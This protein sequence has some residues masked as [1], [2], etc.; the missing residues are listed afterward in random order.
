M[1]RYKDKTI[2]ITGASSGIGKAFA[3]RLDELGAN[4]ILTARSEDKLIELASTM[5]NAC[6][7]PGDLSDREFPEKLYKSVKEK[8]ILSPRS[9]KMRKKL[10]FIQLKMLILNTLFWA[11]KRVKW[12]RVISY[13]LL[14]RSM[15][16]LIF[17]ITSLTLRYQSHYNIKA[18]SSKPLCMTL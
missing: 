6:V 4:I 11:R 1:E 10:L 17:C 5:R 13:G 15:A 7:L 16:Q 18:Y 9:I 8:M 2:L 12:E 14:T 3:R